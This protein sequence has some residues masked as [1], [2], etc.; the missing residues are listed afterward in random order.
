MDKIVKKTE[1]SPF[2]KLKPVDLNRSAEPSTLIIQS[3][4]ENEN[5]NETGDDVNQEKYSKDKHDDMVIIQD[6]VSIN[7]EALVDYQYV[8]SYRKSIL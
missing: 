5:E 2:L 7:M 8:K 3:R 1:K 4:D 6:D